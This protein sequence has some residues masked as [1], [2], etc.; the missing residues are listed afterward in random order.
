MKKRLQNIG[1]VTLSVFICLLILELIFR[2]FNPVKEYSSINDSDFIQPDTLLSYRYTS[3]LNTQLVTIDYS[4]D[5]KTN[6]FGFRDEQWSFDTTQTNLLVLGN[7]FSAGFG[8]NN[9]YRWSDLVQASLSDRSKSIQ[10]YNAAV[11]GFSISQ[12]VNNGIELSKLIQ[13]DIIIVGLYLNS[14]DRIH[15]PLQYYEGFSVR[16]SAIPNAEVID[17][18]IYFSVWET[19]FYKNTEIFLKKNSVLYQFVEE[20]IRFGLFTSL[21]KI[22]RSSPETAKFPEE[23]SNLSQAA[24]NELLRLDTSVSSV[25][26]LLPIIQHNRKFEIFENQAIIYDQLYSLSSDSPIQFIDIRPE[27]EKKVNKGVDMW[28]NND[29]HWN[30]KAHSIAAEVTLQHLLNY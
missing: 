7:S 18:K 26:Y 15:D 1:L 5:I 13:P 2:I 22:F 20:R 19:G 9:E 3:N 16:K 4:I 27:F 8:I 24:F 23:Y 17:G 29:A 10:I 11:S 6:S 28:I 21:K 30:E 14:L 12:A 25:I